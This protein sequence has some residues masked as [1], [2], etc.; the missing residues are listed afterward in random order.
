MLDQI[1]ARLDRHRLAISVIAG[2]WF[3]AGC[4]VYARILTLPDVAA[5]IEQA[6]FWAGAAAN[7]LWYGVAYPRITARRKE[8]EKLR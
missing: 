5:W 6:F 7:A 2:L 8:L 1:I 4:A 3:W